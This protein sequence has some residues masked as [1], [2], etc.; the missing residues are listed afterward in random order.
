MALSMRARVAVVLLLLSPASAAVSGEP[1]TESEAIRLF[2]EESPQAR[3]LPLIV[4]SVNAASRVEARVANPEIAYQIED[5]AGVGDEFLT[6]QQ[7]LP[8]TGRRN[9]VRDSAD[10]AASAAGL[11]AEWELRTAASALREAFYEVL[12]RERV[13]E[14]LR[15]GAERLERVVDILA[16]RESEGEGAGYDLLR[17]EQELAEIG[18]AT[19]EADAEVA[20]ARSRFGAFFQPERKMESARL[21]GDLLPDDLHPDPD[22]AVQRALSQRGDLMALRADAQSLDLEERAARR[23]RFPEPTLTAGWKRTGALDFE[24]WVG[25]GPLPVAV[26]ARFPNNGHS[27]VHASR[28]DHGRTPEL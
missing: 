5:S 15:Q 11:A 1:V 7:E 21:E 6:F 22:E 12:Y 10:A 20:V 28:G 16:K 2:L 8:I 19:S 24:D 17:A 23:R 13:S 3:R 26:R 25:L 27:A 9:L 14:R 18:I 4:E